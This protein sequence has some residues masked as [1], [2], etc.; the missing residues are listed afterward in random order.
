[1]SDK[2]DQDAVTCRPSNTAAIE[3]VE[4]IAGRIREGRTQDRDGLGVDQARRVRLGMR[5]VQANNIDRSEPQGCWD[6]TAAGT[7]GW[8]PQAAFG[9]IRAKGMQWESIGVEAGRSQ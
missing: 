4:G 3:L 6:R 9:P 8:Q 1:M 7:V 2:A 5:N